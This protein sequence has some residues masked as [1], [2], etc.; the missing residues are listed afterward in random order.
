MYVVM[1]R[2]LFIQNYFI[3]SLTTCDLELKINL[4]KQKSSKQFFICSILKHIVNLNGDGTFVSGSILKKKKEQN[5]SL[6]DQYMY[7]NNLELFSIE[8]SMITCF[9]LCI[10]VV[11]FGRIIF[12]VFHPSKVFPSSLPPI[13]TKI[14][15][16]LEVPFTIYTT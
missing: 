11:S 4:K 9:V 14:Y 15:F 8:T 16:V 13:L 10:I 5:I 1:E 12:T 6:D 2:Y 7:L 3:Q